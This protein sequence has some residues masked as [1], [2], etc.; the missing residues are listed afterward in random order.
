MLSSWDDLR[1]HV[2]TAR[3]ALATASR[4]L[5]VDLVAAG[6]GIGLLPTR[7]AGEAPELVELKSFAPKVAELTRSI[8]LL[9]HPDVRH[10]AR[11]KVVMKVLSSHL[12]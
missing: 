10:D 1:E 9:T 2:P 6:A 5:F 4:R 12:R 11:V 8:W 3:I 7:L